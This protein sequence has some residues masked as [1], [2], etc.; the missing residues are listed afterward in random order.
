MLPRR[1]F[2]CSSS[3]L[4][5]VDHA[6]FVGYEGALYIFG[7]YVGDEP[8]AAAWRFSPQMNLWEE[9][10]PMRVPRG[11]AAAAAVGD[12]I[13]VIGGTQAVRTTEGAMSTVEIYDVDAGM[14]TAGP[15]MPTPRHHH[16][17]A[18]IVVVSS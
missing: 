12:R 13:Y 18:A 9:L 1:S 17:A 8:S 4:L 15:D 6:A 11:S 16:D 5:Q 3:V 14:W 7:G 10:A 2:S